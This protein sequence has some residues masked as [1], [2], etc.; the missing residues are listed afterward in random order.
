MTETTTKKSKKSKIKTAELGF[1]CRLAVF[2]FGDRSFFIQVGL[3]SELLVLCIQE[4]AAVIWVGCRLSSFFWR[5]SEPNCLGGDPRLEQKLMN[6]WHEHALGSFR[7][8]WRTFLGREIWVYFTTQLRTSAIE[9]FTLTLYLLYMDA[10][11][12]SL[13][14]TNWR[15]QQ[16]FVV[17]WWHENKEKEPFLICFWKTFN[18]Q[19]TQ[20]H[21]PYPKHPTQT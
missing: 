18:M 4:S 15:A 11:S 14:I 5:F 17:N 19:L 1:L 20:N 2:S 13:C 8:N 3:K 21:D 16:L 10:W 9:Q 7:R 12:D 6:F